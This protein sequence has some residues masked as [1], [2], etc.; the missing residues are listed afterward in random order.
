MKAEKEIKIC[1]N[2][3]EQ[4]PLIWTFAF[5]GAEYWC[6]YC[7]FTGG[8]FGSGENVPE[9]PALLQKAK[10]WKKK[11]NFNGRKNINRKNG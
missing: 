11:G 8:M 5:P 1:S 6:P 4:I 7:G 2:H 9:T 10:E 3:T